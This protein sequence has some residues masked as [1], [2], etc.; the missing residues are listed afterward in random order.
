M[1]QLFFY[2]FL[3]AAASNGLTERT[4]PERQPPPPKYDEAQQ[5]AIYNSN[6]VEYNY[7]YNIGD[8]NTGDYKT[9]HEERQGDVV[10]GSYSLIEPDGSMRIV[11]YTA[12]NKH[13]FKATVRREP[14]HGPAQNYAPAKPIPAPT[15]PSP[16]AESYLSTFKYSPK[17]ALNYALA[18]QTVYPGASEVAQNEYNN[19]PS[20]YN[21]QP[22]YDFAATPTSSLSSYYTGPSS[23]AYSA[24]AISKYFKGPPPN[25]ATSHKSISLGNYVPAPIKYVPNQSSKYS[26]SIRNS[27]YGR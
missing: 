8:E 23:T 25:Y 4:A 1:F 14:G 19:Q 10:K 6:P 3:F 11:D 5:E 27:P 17:P 22:A 15:Q 2:V 20:K 21:S 12:D 24:P 7:Q 13:G 18:Q 16:P 26:A 9:Q